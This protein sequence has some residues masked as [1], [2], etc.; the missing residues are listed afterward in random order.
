MIEEWRPVVG[1][2]GYYEVSNLGGIRSLTR[3]YTRRNGYPYTK[4]GQAIAPWISTHGYLEV[5]LYRE[6][7]KRS[8]RVHQAVAEA[9]LGLKPMPDLEVCHINGEKLDNRA[10]NL[11]WDSHREN[12]IDIKRHGKNHQVNK[13]HCPQGHPYDDKNTYVLPSRPT[14]RYCRA[15]HNQ[16]TAQSNRVKRAARKAEAA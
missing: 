5:R 15:C 14:A 9:F 2:E 13:T 16:R 7:R 11:R 4:R 6:G 1:F 8:L 10:E 12:V 3:T